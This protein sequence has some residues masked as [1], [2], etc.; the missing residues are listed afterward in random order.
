M[1][2]SVSQ[3]LVNE[4]DE[5]ELKRTKI[6]DPSWDYEVKIPIHGGQ[7]QLE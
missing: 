7:E 3:G 1:D 2:Q 4:Q 5:M 6:V